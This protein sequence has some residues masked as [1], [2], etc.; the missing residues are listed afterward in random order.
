MDLRI[1]NCNNFF[2]IKGEL[3]KKSL[4]IFQNEF[5]D[6]FNR[7]SKLTISVEDIKSMDRH[8]VKA[9][10]ELHNEAI[11]KNKSMAIIGFGSKDLYNYFKTNT[12]A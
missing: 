8:G 7:V 5:Q 2:R 1:T 3:N 10:T 11:A 4:S 12:A 9:L 6:I